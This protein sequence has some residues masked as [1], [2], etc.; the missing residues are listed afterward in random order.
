MSQ[1]G[2][3]LPHAVGINSFS[4]PGFDRQHATQVVWKPVGI[5]TRR[6]T[7]APSGAFGCLCGYHGDDEKASLSDAFQTSLRALFQ[8]LW[9]AHPAPALPR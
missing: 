7:A 5:T 6:V 4:S 8:D 2:R 9:G 3:V 1:T